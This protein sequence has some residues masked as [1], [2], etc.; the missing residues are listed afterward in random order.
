[1]KEEHEERCVKYAM[2]SILY[3]N[4]MVCNHIRFIEKDLPQNKEIKRLYRAL[5]NRAYD[6]FSKIKKIIGEDSTWFFADYNATMDEV[7]DP[8]VDEY[9]E[10]ICRVYTKYN[11]PNSDFYARIE[12]LRSLTDISIIAGEHLVEKVTNISERN[13][14][15]KQYLLVDVHKIVQEFATKIY[16][17]INQ[18]IDLNEDKEVIGSLNKVYTE[19]LDYKNFIKS[20]TKA[21]E[22][23]GQQS[24]TKLR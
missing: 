11:I 14:A 19:L 10:N 17:P 8:L 5:E 23:E 18:T 16:K 1:M 3:M 9:K 15:L 13:K 20:Y 12:T 24:N 6:Y 4:D 7:I 22:N 21:G 2:Y